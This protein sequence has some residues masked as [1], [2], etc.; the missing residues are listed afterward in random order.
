[1]Y[2]NDEKITNIREFILE[3]ADIG[4]KDLLF[5]KICCTRRFFNIIYKKLTLN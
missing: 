5:G 2:L 4:D 3:D 1:L